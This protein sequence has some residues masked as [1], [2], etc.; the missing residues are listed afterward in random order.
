MKGMWG[1]YIGGVIFFQKSFTIFSE[2]RLQFFLKS[3]RNRCRLHT[4]AYNIVDYNF[5]I[6]I[7]KTKIVNQKIKVCYCEYYF[8]VINKTKIVNQERK[9][10][11]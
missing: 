8:I 9:V 11:K 2:S 4:F 6:V 10:C 3:L 7:N 5:F 1:G